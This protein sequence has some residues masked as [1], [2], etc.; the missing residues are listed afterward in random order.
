M[1]YKSH[2]WLRCWP[3]SFC[4][5]KWQIG[6]SP[7]IL[8]LSHY[9]FFFPICFSVCGDALTSITLVLPVNKGSFCKIRYFHKISVFFYHKTFLSLFMY[10]RTDIFLLLYEVAMQSS[11]ACLCILN[12]KPVTPLEAL[13]VDH[14]PVFPIHIH[15]QWN[16]HREKEPE[17]SS[18]NPAQ[19]QWR[20]Q[21]LHVHQE[22]GRSKQTQYVRQ[23]N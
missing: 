14:R 10:W 13:R 19:P 21:E 18:F 2:L 12:C 11:E 20:Q 3:L 4:P 6:Y 23:I 1:F 7:A 16:Q 8:V 5:S 15:W 17:N 9:S 22:G